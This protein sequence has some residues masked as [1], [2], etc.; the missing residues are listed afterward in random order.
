MLH[1]TVAGS[2]DV[3][4]LRS[5]QFSYWRPHIDQ[6]SVSEYE[7]SALLY[8]T[9]HADAAVYSPESQDNTP[10]SPAHFSGG[11]LVFH[12]PDVDC[13]VL[14][15]PGVHCDCTAVCSDVRALTAKHACMA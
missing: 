10:E 7:Y 4:L 3:G 1:L 6:V 5:D 13:V 9:K 11:R 8:L 2:L 15:Q 14:P 12:D